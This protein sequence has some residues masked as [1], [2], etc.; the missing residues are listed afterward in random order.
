VIAGAG[1]IREVGGQLVY[2]PSE[3][4]DDLNYGGSATVTIELTLQDN[5]G[6]QSNGTL[7]ATVEGTND[8]VRAY[9]E[10]TTLMVEGTSQL[11]VIRFSAKPDGIAVVANGENL[12]TF[13]ATAIR[14]YGLGGNDTIRATSAILVAVMF[15]GGEGDDTLIGG[16]GDDTLIG[17]AGNDRL[18]GAKGDDTLDGG[19]G[20]DVLNGSRGNDVLLGGIGIDRLLGKAGNDQLFGGLGDDVLSGGS[21]NDLLDGGPGD[22]RISPGSGDDTIIN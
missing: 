7:T 16:G 13:A 1:E 18:T 6:G 8:L 22:D 15:D 14:A 10:D 12:G 3:A 20:K 9:L 4:Y 21:G 5:F 11:D 17:D 2:D 19:E